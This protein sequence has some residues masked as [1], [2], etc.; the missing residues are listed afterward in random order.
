[1]VRARRDGT[2]E[3]DIQEGSEPVSEAD[4][5]ADVVPAQPDAGGRAV[6]RGH[7][8]DQRRVGSV[9]VPSDPKWSAHRAVMEQP[10]NPDDET[11]HA[12]NS[13]TCANARTGRATSAN[14]RPQLWYR[15]MVPFGT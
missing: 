15:L 8:R 10:F 1:M 9:Q 5:L 12:I 7:R 3:L 4:P 14:I 6:R 13:I 2:I 11:G